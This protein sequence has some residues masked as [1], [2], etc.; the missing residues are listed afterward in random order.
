MP[1]L[2]QE[3]VSEVNIVSSKTWEEEH[4]VFWQYGK[5]DLCRGD[6]DEIYYLPGLNITVIMNLSSDREVID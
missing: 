3:I 5:N 1:E 4:V 2:Y 6:G